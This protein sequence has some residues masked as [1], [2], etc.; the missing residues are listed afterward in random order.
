MPEVREGEAYL[1]LSLLQARVGGSLVSRL[2]GGRVKDVLEKPAARISREMNLTE[3]AARALAEMRQTFEARAL[4][5]RLG[6][7]GVQTITLADEAYPARLRVAP[8]PPPALF[9]RGRLAPEALVALVGSRKATPAGVEMARS[10]GRELAARG[11]CVVSGLALGVDAA[12]HEGALEA[13]GETM[14][15]LGCGIDVVYPRANRGLFRRV[16]ERGALVSEYAPGEAPLAW[17]FP[18]R[19]RIIAGLSDAVVVVE[20]PEKSGALIT[21]RHA[22]D[23]GRDVWAVPGPPGVPECRGS[24]RLLADGAGVLWDLPEFLD[25]VA[26]RAGDKPPPG[27]A[28]EEPA[29][30]EP[31]LPDPPIGLPEE[32]AGVLRGVD[33]RSV[34]ADVVA[35]RTGVE[36]KVVLSALAM[37]EIKGYVA[38]DAAGNFARRSAS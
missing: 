12:A 13:G 14:G 8:D 21:A 33:F 38:R 29:A 5:G 6:H 28:P 11:V 24:N 1:F 30:P 32:E 3:R 25:A 35:G 36:M 19:N 26:G 4:L 18:A 10:L 23:A 20:A 34:G 2:A 15:V 37:L 7:A 31:A 17:R 9:V 16:E 22:L 27:P